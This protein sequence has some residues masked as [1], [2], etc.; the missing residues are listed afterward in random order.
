MFVSG[1]DPGWALDL[2]PLVL[3]GVVADITEIRAQEIFNYAYYDQPEIVRE[4]I[5]FGGPMDELPMMLW[6][7]ALEMVWAPM[8][9]LVGRALGK[10]VEGI[11]VKVERLPLERT[12]EVEGMG[13][14]EAG[15]QGA[16]RFEV[17]GSAPASVVS[18]SPCSCWLK[19]RASQ[20]Q[21]GN[22]AITPRNTAL[23]RLSVAVAAE[24][25]DASV[26]KPVISPNAA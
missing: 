12:I 4:V 9:R 14:F 20:F 8:V 1:I 23:K 3:S 16:F 6:D 18:S 19:R 15:T 13:T 5:G 24:K 26:L 2:L 10:P 21:P 17:I 25:N 7:I 22:M 11:E